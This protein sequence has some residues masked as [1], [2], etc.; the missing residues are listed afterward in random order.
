[1]VAPPQS[2]F[3]IATQSCCI[4]CP[5]EGDDPT[6]WALA[7]NIGGKMLKAVQR[8][9]DLLDARTWK[10]MLESE[11]AEAAQAGLDVQA[12]LNGDVVALLSVVDYIA[13]QTVGFGFF[14]MLQGLKLADRLG[15][16]WYDDVIGG[17]HNSQY[18]PQL[19]QASGDFANTV[20]DI[21][22]LKQVG[23]LN[24]EANGAYR[25]LEGDAGKVMDNFAEKWGSS[26][27]SIGTGRWQVVSPDGN[28]ILTKYPSSDTPYPTLQI[29]EAGAIQKIRFGSSIY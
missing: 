7:K 6:P 29:N 15:G 5:D 19:A 1:M 24:E 12:A 16:G 3:G 21:G 10:N 26:V 13:E 28:T 17:L 18:F 9:E 11:W 20:D 4:R 23:Q 14:D 2:V 8:G 27:Q 22:L 25:I